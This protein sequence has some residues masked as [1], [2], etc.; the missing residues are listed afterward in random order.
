MGSHAGEE[1]FGFRPTS[2]KIDWTPLEHH[3]GCVVDW[4]WRSQIVPPPV[5]ITWC[6]QLVGTDC[7]WHGGESGDAS[8]DAQIEVSDGG[9]GLS[10]PA[11]R[12]TGE[13][14]ALGREMT[15]QLRTIFA[16]VVG[17]TPEQLKEQVPPLYR[18]RM[19]E[20]GQDPVNSWL[21][22]QLTNIVLNHGGGVSVEAMEALLQQNAN[23]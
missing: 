15:S 9:H 12:A 5:F 10:F 16:T 20:Q 21:D 23:T 8:E 19:E 6:S 4:G 14:V 13:S 3:C 17:N 22:H 7:P 18:V 2:P 1:A 11:R